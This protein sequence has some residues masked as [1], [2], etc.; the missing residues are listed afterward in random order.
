MPK[1]EKS[2]AI[3]PDEGKE[4]KKEKVEPT[5][6]EVEFKALVMKIAENQD[7]KDTGRPSDFEEKAFTVV[8]FILSGNDIRTSCALAGLSSTSYYR[9]RE[10]FKEFR[11]IL[12]RALAYCRAARVAR[13]LRASE[14]SWQ[15]AAW[16]LERM[17]SEDFALKSILETQED[18]GRDPAE[19]L[20][21]QL[22]Q[23]AK[24]KASGKKAKK[25][26]EEDIEEVR[27]IPKFE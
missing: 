10:D 7:K 22:A 15:A 26:K 14:K 25:K 6:A 11:D 16:W 24:E 8:R 5:E 19:L 21:E 27:D 18:K 20:M 12:K 1:N 13:I 4:E 17:Y 9:W 3:D 23:R 2:E